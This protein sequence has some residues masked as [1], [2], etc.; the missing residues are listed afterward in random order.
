[1]AECITK[2]INQSLSGTSCTV[3]STDSDDTTGAISSDI[4]ITSESDILTTHDQEN[5]IIVAGTTVLED[6][7]KLKA[8]HF[9]CY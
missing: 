5:S 1:M 7:T 8:T 3:S 9:Y 4:L 2:C 6:T